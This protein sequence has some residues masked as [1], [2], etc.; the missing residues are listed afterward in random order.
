MFP[1]FK[2][3]A[4]L[5]RALCL[6]VGCGLVQGL[7]V[8]NP[9]A[10]IQFVAVDDTDED[11][12]SLHRVRQAPLDTELLADAPGR[13]AH[14]VVCEGMAYWAVNG[15]NSTKL[16]RSR[17]GSNGVDLLQSYNASGAFSAHLETDGH[18]VYWCAQAATGGSLFFGSNRGSQMVYV[19]G[20]SGMAKKL[21]V[22]SQEAYL[23][24][25]EPIGVPSRV[26]VERHRPG[27]ASS[28]ILTSVNST[29]SDMAH[30]G[31]HLW[32]LVTRQDTS[33]VRSRLHRHLLGVMGA[34]MLQEINGNGKQVQV[35]NGKVVW[36]VNLP[37]NGG[38][39]LYTRTA[40]G[41]QTTQFPF[42]DMVDSSGIRLTE[43]HGLWWGQVPGG[44][45]IRAFD[46]FTHENTNNTVY[47]SSTVVASVQREEDLVVAL[48]STDASP[49][50][51]VTYQAG[52]LGL[53]PNPADTYNQPVHALGAG[54][55]Q[56]MLLG[57]GQLV[58]VDH[59]HRTE[60]TTLASGT[61][62]QF[63]F[64]TESPKGFIFAANQAPGE[65][66]LYRY[67]AGYV[68]ALGNPGLDSGTDFQ[69]R[70]FYT[71]N[72]RVWMSIESG[73]GR[74]LAFLPVSGQVPTAEVWH[75]APTGWSEFKG[76]ML[77]QEDGEPVAEEPAGR[78]NVVQNRQGSTD[79]I[80]SPSIPV[81]SG[82]LAQYAGR[83]IYR[84]E[85]VLNRL[86]LV[87]LDQ[88]D[89]LVSYPQT[90]AADPDPKGFLGWKGNLIYHYATAEGKRQLVRLRRTG[91]GIPV[92]HE[93]D[94]FGPLFAHRGYLFFV[95]FEE[96]QEILYRL[97][98]P[99]GAAHPVEN[100][101]SQG[102]GG[103]RSMHA[104]GAWVYGAAEW[105][106]GTVA[107]AFTAQDF[108][109]LAPSEMGQ[110]DGL[111]DFCSF[112][113]SLYARTG[114]AGSDLWRLDQT[115]TWV[116]AHSTALRDVE[117]FTEYAGAL[118]FTAATDG[119]RN[120]YRMA[121]S[122]TTR[123]DPPIP[124]YT[125]TGFN[126]RALQRLQGALVFS[127]ASGTDDRELWSYGVFLPAPLGFSMVSQSGSGHPVNPIVDGPRNIQLSVA[128][129]P[130]N[131]PAGVVVGQLTAEDAENGAP[132]ILDV[133]RGFSPFPPFAVEANQLKLAQPST[134]GYG[135][136]LDLWIRATNAKGIWNRSKIALEVLDNRQVWLDRYF[137]GEEENPELTGDDADPDG[138]GIN[139]RFERAFGLNPNLANG[140]AGMFK[141]AF[142]HI[143]SQPENARLQIEFQTPL[144]FPAGLAIVAYSS[145]DLVEWE[146]LGNL[147]ADGFGEIIWSSTDEAVEAEMDV[148]NGIVRYRIR[149]SV[150]VKDAPKR[151][152]R[153]EVEPR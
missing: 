56:V 138:D 87:S 59:D 113:G 151:F 18:V 85:S 95:A 34:P 122:V 123:L 139:N 65:R 78:R 1:S 14:V 119:E 115:E 53:M 142:T 52:D 44:T 23:A 67:N 31:Q 114:G 17:Y 19:D 60:T 26:V 76:R 132:V 45:R 15:T 124:I 110:L 57:G 103:L 22:H 82:L 135:S 11:G 70:D 97:G 4:M 32:A 75:R 93:A 49:H 102:L 112:Q 46:L 66:N 62:A 150:D 126:P 141:P 96:G 130:E 101:S 100:L 74:V 58:G 98:A 12:C 137:P 50:Q 51:V 91:G 118:Y 147:A 136:H 92:I 8:A 143:E 10:E 111:V 24:T 20:F 63:A 80:G 134:R 107:V 89:E 38:A 29:F 86:R 73:A 149:D 88:P 21:L 6:I 127:A 7:A 3:P 68:D 69:P 25:E 79:Y 83:A 37:D 61:A 108:Q 2:I 41:A 5:G 146:Q 16:Y 47:P 42:T 71:W 64:G 90:A 145:S 84:E 13:T 40:D 81:S 140:T 120:L 125:D 43:N 109:V 105:P 94:A 39:R 128:S 116:P 148:A 133:Y 99:T 106:G 9:G 129:I 144:A 117:E 152:L 35:W 104:H 54:R 48:A 36:S 131:L 153:L 30:D 27:S 121:G 55:W 77:F 33:P 28:S 72:D